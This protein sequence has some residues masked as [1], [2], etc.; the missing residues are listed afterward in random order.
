MKTTSLLLVVLIATLGACSKSESKPETKP[1]TAKPEPAKP[2]AKAGPDFAA[3]D[4]EGKAKAWQGA[5]LVKEN[6]TI[7]AWV[8]T[9]DK[10]QT[11]DGKEEKTYTLK[12]V[13]PCRAFF[14]TESGMQYPREFGVTNGKVRFR[15]MGAGV[16]K[17]AEAFF[18]DGSGEWFVLDAAGKCTMW[19]DDFG[20]MTSAAAECGLKKDAAGAEVFFHKGTNEGEFAIEGDAILSSTSF[21]TE[22]VVGDFAA[23]KAAREAKAATP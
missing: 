10:V 5:W 20:K 4:M 7:Q 1:E 21:D 12:V 13:A 11:W 18:C 6:G 9:G 15:S 17:G 19:K 8:V 16:R 23:A 22:A 14:A 2:A 3:W